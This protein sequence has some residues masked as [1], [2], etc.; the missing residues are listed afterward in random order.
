MKP[1]AVEQGAGPADDASEWPTG[2]PAL[3]QQAPGGAPHPY[4]CDKA[5]GEGRL[6]TQPSAVYFKEL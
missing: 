2:R 6:R 3:L 4:G 5:E 1:V